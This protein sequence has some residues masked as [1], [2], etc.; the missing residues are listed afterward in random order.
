MLFALVDNGSPW[1]R[2]CPSCFIFIFVL[3]IFLI[4]SF[5]FYFYCPMPRGEWHRNSNGQSVSLKTTDLDLK[6]KVIGQGQFIWDYCTGVREWPWFLLLCVIDPI[7]DFNESRYMHIPYI[8]D[9]PFDLFDDLDLKVKVTGH[10]FWKTCTS[11]I[12]APIQWILTKVGTWIDLISRMC[13][14]TFSVTLTSRSRSQVTFSEK[15]A[16]QISPQ[17]SDG[18]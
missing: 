4:F 13:L 18:F 15:L 9:V 11:N 14:L 7:L 8:K 16:R 5:L 12:S 1:H 6:V 3:S 10:V 17:P 2:R